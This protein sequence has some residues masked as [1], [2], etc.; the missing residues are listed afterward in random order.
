MSLP[1]S[2]QYQKLVYRE[3]RLVGIS[4]INSVLD[5]GI[6]YQLIKRQVDLGDIK[7]G[8]STAPRETGRLLMSRI[9]C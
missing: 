7:K 2:Q 5:P 6:M 1:A 3:N 8:F 4:C 9:W